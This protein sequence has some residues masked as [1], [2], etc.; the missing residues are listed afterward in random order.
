MCSDT[1]GM[2]R[3][4]DD[5]FDSYRNLFLAF[6]SRLSDIRPRQRVLKRRRFGLRRANNNGRWESEKH[7]FM[8]ALSDADNLVPLAELTP[9]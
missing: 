1:S 5:L 3:T 6:E 2:C 4:S 9:H 7:W 8:D